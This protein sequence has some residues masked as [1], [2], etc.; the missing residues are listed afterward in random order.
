MEINKACR[1]LL[2]GKGAVFLFL[3]N[4]LKNAVQCM[5]FSINCFNSTKLILD[6]IIHRFSTT[7]FNYFNY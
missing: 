3:K 5:K 1:I 2:T 7:L 4:K 6:E